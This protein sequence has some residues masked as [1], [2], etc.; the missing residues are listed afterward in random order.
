MHIKAKHT[1]TLERAVEP[2]LLAVS[3]SETSSRHDDKADA[4]RASK[5]DR[6]WVISPSAS[7]GFTLASSNCHRQHDQHVIDDMSS[8]PARQSEVITAC[9]AAPGRGLG[10]MATSL[11]K[12]ANFACAEMKQEPKAHAV[13]ASRC[14]L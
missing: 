8:I 7:R 11:T 5:P 4:K 3:C 6:K 1:C 14:A 10:M 9:M 2:W 13:S 12:T